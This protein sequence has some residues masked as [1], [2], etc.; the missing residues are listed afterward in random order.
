MTRRWL[1]AGATLGALV[2]LLVFAPAAW[3]ARQV[4]TATDGRLFLADARGTV[5]H[6]DA[7]VVL[8][9]GLDSREARALPGRLQ[10]RL[11]L[12]GMAPALWLEQACC[13]DR[14][15]LLRLQPGLSRLRVDV[16]PLPADATP[17]TAAV[18]PK[19]SIARW[20]VEWL[21]GLGAP[22]NTLRPSGTM[23][24]SGQALAV[25]A[26]QGRVVM[27]GQAELQLNNIAS[28][29][30]TLN[31]LGDYVLSLQGDPK[32][33]AATVQ[34][35][36][37]RGPLQLSGTG[38]W[39]AS[40]L[41]FRGQASAAPGFEPALNNLLNIIGRRQGALSVLSIG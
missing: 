16:D 19:R 28:R 26:V 18:A 27:L 35:R 37:T 34:L 20:P 15:L 33:D 36:T 21:E 11:G 4:T 30:S 10:W 13:I 9:G 3:L 12:D 41:R 1:L 5:W 14:P 8:T 39:A 38:Q 22:W 40:R 25:E 29:V 7:V 24:L 2:A 17:A 6:G 23:Q 32:G 31:A